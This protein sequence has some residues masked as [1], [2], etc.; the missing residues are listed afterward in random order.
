[1]LEDVQGICEPVEGS[2]AVRIRGFHTGGLDTSGELELED[3]ENEF[4]TFMTN[5]S[6]VLAREGK[7]Q[8]VINAK[9]ES[10]ID[11]LTMWGHF[12]EVCQ[13]KGF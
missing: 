1:M 7:A 10:H 6:P 5:C 3:G 4:A 12:K 11:G 13:E 8:D 2:I 9:S